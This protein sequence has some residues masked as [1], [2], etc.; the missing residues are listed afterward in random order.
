MRPYIELAI[1]ILK[2][3]KNKWVLFDYRHFSV[4]RFIIKLLDKYI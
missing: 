4:E 2:E 3:D 1:T